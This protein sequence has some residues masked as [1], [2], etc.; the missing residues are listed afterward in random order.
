MNTPRD[1]EYEVGDPAEKLVADE[2]ERT[3]GRAG[4][5]EEQELLEAAELEEIEFSNRSEG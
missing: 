1:I 5:I 4:S 2:I 3:I